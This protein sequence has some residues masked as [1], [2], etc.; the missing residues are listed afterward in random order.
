MHSW[1]LTCFMQLRMSFLAIHYSIT[2]ICPSC[3]LCTGPQNRQMLSLGLGAATQ[4]C[5]ALPQLYC[6]LQRGSCP[7]TALPPCKSWEPCRDGRQ[8]CPKPYQHG[9]GKSCSNASALGF[10]HAHQCCNCYRQAC[11]SQESWFGREQADQS[12]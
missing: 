8:Q 6:T 5:G 12:V 10:L 11:H 4:M 2:A 9:C 3:C 1:Q 7:T